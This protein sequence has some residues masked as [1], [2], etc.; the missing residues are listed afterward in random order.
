MEAVAVINYVALPHQKESSMKKCYLFLAEGF[1]ESEAV[2]VTDV[3]RRGILDITLVSM[4]GKLAVKGSHEITVV[5]DHLFEDCD[6]TTAD[7]LVLPGGMPGTLN[8]KRDVRLAELLIAYNAQQRLLA[9]ICAAPLVLGQLELLK[10]REATV[11]P[12]FED[13]LIGATILDQTI[14]VSE[15]IITS[16]GVVSAVEFGL[17]L[18]QLLQSEE[19]YQKTA[20]SLLVL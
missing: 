15:N 11:F 16:R 9:A 12:G 14:V 10:G 20:K 6:F 1:E 5:A 19:I 2:I 3:L 4:T 18:V 13:Q 8:L 7:L 17:K